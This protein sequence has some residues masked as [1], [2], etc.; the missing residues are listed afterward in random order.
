MPF[1][2]CQRYNALKSIINTYNTNNMEKLL[3]RYAECRMTEDK[4]NEGEIGQTTSYE[5][6]HA[7]GK[8]FTNIEQLAKIMHLQL[9]EKICTAFDDRILI[10]FLV[11]ENERELSETELKLWKKG[12]FKAYSQTYDVGVTII[13]ET[14]TT[15]ELTSKMLNI[16][17]Y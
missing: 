3:I 10:D 14:E 16:T 13:Q 8:T 2:Y 15:Q 9:T 6:D 17:Q 11:D 12:K 7:A 1:T 5:V 4:Y